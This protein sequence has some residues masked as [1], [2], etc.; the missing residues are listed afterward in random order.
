MLARA[1]CDKAAKDNE[2]WTA[3]MMAANS[4]IAAAARRRGVHRGPKRGIRAL[5][6]AG[7]DCCAP[8][9]AGAHASKSIIAG[10][11]S[12]DMTWIEAWRRGDTAQLMRGRGAAWRGAVWRALWM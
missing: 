7:D 10:T 3:L 1:G 12:A 8:E 5:F 9:G 11:P 6:V 4:G 2:G